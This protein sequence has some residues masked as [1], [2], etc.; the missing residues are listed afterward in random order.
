[1][2]IFTS[3]GSKVKINYVDEFKNVNHPEIV[4]WF[5]TPDLL[6]NERYLSDLDSI[7]KNSPFD[8]VFI[9][10][11]N[12]CDFYDY[13]KMTPIFAKLVERAHKLGIKIGLQLWNYPGKVDEK[14]C[15]H[16]LTEGEI[17]LDNNGNGIYEACAKH[18]RPTNF[19]KTKDL[20]AYRTELYRAFA[21][22]KLADV[23]YDPATLK[24]ISI[25]CKTIKKTTGEK[26]TIQINGDKELAGYTVYLMVDHFYNHPDMYSYASQ[27][28]EDIL[29]KYAQIQFDGTALD[30]FG[31]MRITPPWEMKQN[32]MFTERFFSP[33][34]GEGLEKTDQ[35][36]AEITLLHLRYYPKDSMQVRMRAINRYMD[37]LREGPLT[38]ENDFYTISKKIFGINCFI[39]VHNTFH[40]RLVGDE[41]WITGVNWWRIK[42][43]YGQTD[44]N[45]SLPVQLGIALSNSKNVLYNMYYNPNADNICEKA[46]TDLRYGIRTHYHAIND[47]QWGIGLESPAFLQKVKKVEDAARLLNRFNP[48]QPETKLLVIFGTEALA[49]WF[50]DTKNQS[51]YNINDKLKIEEKSLA[52]LKAGFVNALVPS[53]LIESGLLTLNTDNK[54]CLN[55]RV[56]D[57]L[58][59]L[60]PQYAR[61]RTI[62]FLEKYTNNGGKLMLEGEATNDF[63][64][65]DISD[66][67]KK[68]KL[69][70]TVSGFDLTK[71]QSLNIIENYI[72]GG[73][74]TADS[75]VVLTDYPSVKSNKPCNFSAELEGV[76]YSGSYIGMLGLKSINGE[77]T[78]ITSTGLIELKR[79]NKKVLKFN[80][81]QSLF[82]ET[83]GH[84]K[85]LT[86]LD[87][88]KKVKPIICIL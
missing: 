73:C 23:V 48:A 83:I 69:K 54:P 31:Y 3:C 29:L 68:I 21:F 46:M 8:L 49:N 1:M 30:E 16:T 78:K 18:I 81:P 63:N 25:F 4:Y 45:S 37:V 44:E 55:G 60:Y 86:L 6:L 51:A 20:E 40:N 71:I 15:Q 35:T 19:Y 50:P 43:D 24:D 11:R 70:S 2:F 36:P 34:M 64:G 52:L 76:N 38:V 56:F 77:L 59:Y 28:F 72:K 26:A 12:G 33:K 14:F 5:F 80:Q 57:A 82:F 27:S 22:K 79:E 74:Y 65:V 61:E 39:G 88:L 13:K 7:A 58:I 66:R 84:E 75:S 41:M 17:T 67:F 62:Q 9:S 53:D 47:K 87:E 85:V 32:E 42:R 10:A